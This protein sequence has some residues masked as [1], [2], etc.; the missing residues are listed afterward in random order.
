M[1]ERNSSSARDSASPARTFRP[2][3]SGASRGFTS[4]SSGESRGASRGYEGHNTGPRNSFG[5]SSRPSYRGGSS[6]RDSRGS[7]RPSF[8]G[9]GSSGRSSGGRGGKNFGTYIDPARFVNR[10]QAVEDVVAYVPEHRFADFDLLPEVKAAIT[11]RGYETP[12]PIQDKAI[13]H[14]LKGMDVVGIADTGTGKTGAFLVPLINKIYADRSQYVLIVVPT[15]ELAIQIETELLSLTKRQQ[16]GSVSVVGGANIQ[17]QI[18]EL[19]R[20]PHF[21]IG[22]PGRLKDVIDRRALDLSAFSTIV[23][24]EADRMLD[25]GFIADI[26]QLV[27]GMK[28]DRQTLFFSATLSSDIEKLIGEFLNDSPVRVSLKTRDTSKNV[29]QD[30]VRV[31]R[32]SDKFEILSEVLQRPE[33]TKA[34]IF[35]RTKHGVEKLAH[36]LVQKGFKA[37][38]IHGN[39]THNNRQKALLRFRNDHSQV[40]VATDVAARGLDIPGVS[41]V[42]NFDVPSTHEDYVHRIG[43]TGRG[44][45]RGIAL[46]FIE[47]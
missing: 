16:V 33:V 38:S 7:S 5:S 45:A 47:G 24:D 28:K 13:P 6:D 32:G 29:E 12:T 40:M 36:A 23:L 35:G 10:A 37:E 18:R 3:R 46:T 4:A 9:R 42:I 8:G 30:V 2:R 41:H 17:P 34:L 20:H 31:P 26:R 27:S 15:R 44:D 1:Y 19:R 14:V 43:R 39:K 11:A 25:M 21:V 22:T